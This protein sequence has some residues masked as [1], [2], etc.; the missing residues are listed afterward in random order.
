MSVF[1]HSN[2]KIHEKVDS[3][4]KKHYDPL[5]K[6]DVKQ[7]AFPKDPKNDNKQLLNTTTNKE[8]SVKLKEELHVRKESHLTTKHKPI[9][10][11]GFRKASKVENWRKYTLLQAQIK[12]DKEQI[13]R[14]MAI[15]KQRSVPWLIPNF[16]YSN[17]Y[18][19]PYFF[20][21][22]YLLWSNFYI[23]VTFYITRTK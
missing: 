13:A 15:K 23:Y 22:L 18:F 10:R 6:K 14:I 3:A 5:I 9:C 20:V 2:F 4:L 1:S 21:F 17:L 19:L 12:S 11:Y 8:Y 7:E 16:L